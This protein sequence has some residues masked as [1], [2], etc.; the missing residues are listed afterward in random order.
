M[1]EK[2]NHENRFI[3]Q[4][5]V[6]A[7]SPANKPAEHLCF[8]YEYRFAEHVNKFGKQLDLG[9]LNFSSL[10]PE[11]INSTFSRGAGAAGGMGFGAMIFLNAELQSGINLLKSMAQLKKQ[12]QN[13]DW[14]ITGEGQLDSQTLSG[15][16]VKGIINEIDTQKVAVFCAINQLSDEEIK[17]LNIS[18]CKAIISYSSSKEDSIRHAKKYLLILTEDYLSNLT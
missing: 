11:H 5:V 16:V 15:K 6:P 12:I 9:L 1:T 10:F 4:F 18:Y 3:S 13:A 7:V 17:R 14:I 2:R 8:E